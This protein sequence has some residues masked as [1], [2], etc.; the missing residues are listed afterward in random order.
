M[1]LVAF[2]IG[3]LQLVIL[4]VCIEFRTRSNLLIFNLITFAPLMGIIG[5][6]IIFNIA[7]EYILDSYSYREADFRFRSFVLNNKFIEW[8]NEKRW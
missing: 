6:I 3:I 2:L 4:N 8:L 5:I 7:C 1:T